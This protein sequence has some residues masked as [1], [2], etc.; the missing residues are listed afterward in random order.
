MIRPTSIRLEASSRCQLRCPSCPTAT[1]AIHPAIGS[2]CLRADDFSR[3]I[4]DN[5]QLG[6]IELSNYGEIFLNPQLLDILRIAH[7]RR[8]ALSADNG[9]N[10]NDVR[11][12]VLEGLVRYGLRTLSCSIDGCSPET[13]AV[14]RVGG[15]FDAV[16]RNIEAI[17]AH[18]RAYRSEFPRLRWQFIVFGHNE[19]ELERARELASRLGMSFFIKLSWDDAASPLRDR[20]RVR[21]ESG[22]SSRAEFRKLHGRDYAHGI[23][24]QLW[25]EPQINW[26]GGVLGCCRNFWGTF[27]GNAFR[28]GLRASVNSERMNYARRMLEG[29]AEPRADIPCATCDLYRDR[30]ARG[31]WRMR[32]EG[33][34]DRVKRFARRRGKF[35]RGGRRVFAGCGR[36]SPPRRAGPGSGRAGRRKRGDSAP[37]R[38]RG[39]S[40]GGSATPRPGTAG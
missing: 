30:R 21:R 5:P 40:R 17:N 29:L 39:R 6:R 15:S 18:K 35:I 26:D 34:T 31:I 37:T 14:Y 38:S 8:V 7:E 12:E 25:E 4:D 16:I 3:L 1:G 28:D 27:G 11:G 36:Q 2:G 9:A 19:H 10:L 13:Y 20:E 24:R 33:V 23:C 32:F 22:A